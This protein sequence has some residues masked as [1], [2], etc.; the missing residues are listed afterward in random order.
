MA[1][2]NIT[3]TPKQFGVP[4]TGGPTTPVATPTTTTSVAT[5]AVTDKNLTDDV[6]GYTT[7]VPATPPATQVEVKPLVATNQEFLAAN[8]GQLQG[9]TP[10]V[11]Q[12]VA[13]TSTARTPEQVKADLVTA[14]KSGDNIDKI[15]QEYQFAQGQVDNQSTVK[16]QLGELMQDFEGGQTP[17]W[18]AG[19]MRAAN[20]QMAARGLGASSIAAGATTQAAME[21]ALPIAQQD[22][23]TY[24]TM[25]LANLNNEQQMLMQKNDARTQSFFSDVA[26]ENATRQFNASSKT[27]VAQFNANLKST[28]DQFNASQVNAMNEF[29]SGQTNAIGMFKAEMEDQRQQFNASNRLIVDQSNVQWRRQVTTTNN[30]ATNEANMLEAQLKSQMTLAQYNNVMQSR[31]DAMNYA[32]T[33]SENAATRASEL[34]MA[35]MSS[36]EAKEARKSASKDSMWAGVGSLVAAW[37]R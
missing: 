26:T 8:S 27:Q 34:V 5:S 16:G 29:N 21:S 2:T 1:T 3:T 6:A 37:L 31:R 15:L 22:A 11:K 12:S 10:T 7:A 9:A 23:Q 32:F 36:D 33:A 25:Q 19:A 18:A 20:D 24:M 17:A 4:L 14:V 35:L 30:A 13:T 28:V